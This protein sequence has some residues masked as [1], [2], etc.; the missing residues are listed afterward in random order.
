MFRRL[1]GDEAA[2]VFQRDIDEIT[3]E[4]ADEWNRVCYPLFS[5]K[6]GYVEETRRRMRLA[7]QTTE[8][9]LHYWRNEA[10]HTDPWEL[11]AN[12]RC[13]ALVIAGE[14]DPICPLPLVEDFVRHLT[15]ASQVE[16]LRLRGARHAVFRDAPDIVFPALLRF[17]EEHAT[18]SEV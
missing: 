10:P 9:N 11:L 5:A 6:P 7:I 1:G 2:A 16:L 13:P 12:V 3:A 17:L 18:G 4:S 8:V 15:N 14:D